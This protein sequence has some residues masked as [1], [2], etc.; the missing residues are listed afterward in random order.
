MTGLKSIL[1][2]D[3]EQE[4]LDFLSLLLKQHVSGRIVPTRFPTQ[5][6]QLARDNCFEIVLLD[7]TF[8]F[9]GSQFGGL[10]VY[11]SL[12]DRYGD[13]S[14]VVY[15]HYITDELLQRYNMPF[16]F[17]EKPTD[18]L[19]W[20]PH[21]V[22]DLTRYRG[23]QSCFVAMPFGRAFDALFEIIRGCVESAGYQCARIDRQVFTDSIVERIFREI[24]KAK[25]V[26]FVATGANANVFY[27][28]GYAAALGKEII[29]VTDSHSVLPF[30][31]RDRNAIS[32]GSDPMALIGPL[33]NILGS[34]TDVTL[35]VGMV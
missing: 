27:E 1:I 9:N 2:L 32:Y 22:E 12:L 30:D 8:S 35:A 6:I 10:E 24:R 31:V 16:N 25:L 14:L 5:A 17:V 7:V 21:F 23:R 4:P 15:S 18:I 3:D 11:K 33:T 20:I 13:S 28:A 34:I 29:T 26:V 19:H